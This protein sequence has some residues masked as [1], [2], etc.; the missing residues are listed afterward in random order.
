MGDGDVSPTIVARREYN[1]VMRGGYIPRLALLFL[2]CVSA[3]SFGQRVTIRV[4]NFDGKP[5]K[6]K[7][8]YISG[9]SAPAASRKDEQLKLTGKPIRA[10]LS[11]LTDSEGETAF[12]L[13]NPAPAYVYVRTVFSERVWDCTCLVNV[14]TDRLLREGFIHMSF[15]GRSKPKPSIQPKAGEILFVMGRTPLWWQFLYPIEKG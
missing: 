2:C 8:V 4:I 1:S 7:Q 15:V 13:P 12:D 14:P 5:F 10:D 9:L 11:L 6:N 3:A